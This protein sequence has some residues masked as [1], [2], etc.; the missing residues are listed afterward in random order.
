MQSILIAGWNTEQFRSHIQ[1][2]MSIEYGSELP[3]YGT[4]F[5]YSEQDGWRACDGDKGFISVSGKPY[6]LF[7]YANIIQELAAMQQGAQIRASRS[8]EGNTLQVI[9]IY[10]DSIDPFTRDQIEQWLNSPVIT[11]SLQ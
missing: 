10:P 3:S 6:C 2:R 7:G 5:L 9:F 8:T 1:H 4:G 11:P